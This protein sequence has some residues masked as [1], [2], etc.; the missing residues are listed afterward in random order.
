MSEKKLFD[1]IFQ[2]FF[3]KR[4]CYRLPGSSIAKLLIQFAQAKSTKG[5]VDLTIQ[6][7]ISLESTV[8]IQ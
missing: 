5:W 7:W 1:Q 8:F 4:L 3:D 6:V 2:S